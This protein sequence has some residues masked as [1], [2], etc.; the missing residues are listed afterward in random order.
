[1]WSKNPF[2]TLASSNT[3]SMKR[4]L[5]PHSGHVNCAFIGKLNVFTLQLGC[6]RSAVPSP[7]KDVH[8]SRHFEPGSFLIPPVWFRCRKTDRKPKHHHAN[9]TR[10]STVEP[11]VVDRR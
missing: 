10:S 3:T 5:F 6:Y 1:M 8:R 7:R 9:Q 2:T 4:R 11:N